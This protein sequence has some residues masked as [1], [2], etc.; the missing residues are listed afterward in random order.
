LPLILYVMLIEGFPPAGESFPAIEAMKFGSATQLLQFETN[1]P[2]VVL[3]YEGRT[4]YHIT[5]DPA[6][7]DAQKDTPV[8]AREQ[9]QVVVNEAHNLLKNPEKLCIEPPKEVLNALHNG[10]YKLSLAVRKA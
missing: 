9:R 10:A 7:P 8:K 6:Q 1:P 2:V 5:Q 4:Y 3:E